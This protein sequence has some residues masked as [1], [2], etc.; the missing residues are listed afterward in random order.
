M[1]AMKPHARIVALAAVVSAAAAQAAGRGIAAG[2][3]T[4][5]A[6]ALA[7]VGEVSFAKDG[8][9]GIAWSGRAGVFYVLRDLSGAWEPAA[10]EHRFFRAILT[11]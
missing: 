3:D 9:G 4:T 7:K 6:L 11:R 5:N 1:A 10:P 2:P 8:C